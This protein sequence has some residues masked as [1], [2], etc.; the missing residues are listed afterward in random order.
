[1]LT[2]TL[3]TADDYERTRRVVHI[4]PVAVVAVEEAELGRST[5]GHRR[6]AAAAEHEAKALAKALKNGTD[7]SGDKVRY[8]RGKAV[9]EFAFGGRYSAWI[10]DNDAERLAERLVWFCGCVLD[11]LRREKG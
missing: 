6:P 5:C 8:Q 9:G 1:M 2:F 3:Y 7:Y 4:D 11:D 10:S